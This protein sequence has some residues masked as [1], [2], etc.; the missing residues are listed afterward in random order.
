MLPAQMSHFSLPLL[1]LMHFFHSLLSQPARSTLISN[2]KAPFPRQT[3]HHLLQTHFQGFVHYMRGTSDNM[4]AK[5][6]YLTSLCHMRVL[7]PIPAT[8]A[9]GLIQ[10][11]LL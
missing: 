2:P 11:M 5:P 6:F 10:G 9:G 3:Q 4:A 7:K 8:K 1:A